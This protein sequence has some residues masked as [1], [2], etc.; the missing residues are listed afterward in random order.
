[1]HKYKMTIQFTIIKAMKNKLYGITIDVEIYKDDIAVFYGDP[2]IMFEWG[3]RKY[4]RNFEQEKERLKDASAY[5]FIADPI[6]YNIPA[7][8]YLGK[9]K[10]NWGS[11]AHEV[12]HY[13]MFLLAHRNVGIKPDDVEGH[14]ALTY[15]VGWI[16]S[17]IQATNFKEYNFKTKKWITPQK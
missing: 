2:Q 3:V 17:K 11:I 16:V 13:S 14:E 10:R 7:F 8:I 15:L 4:G 12:L 5:C 6:G 9:N 1:M